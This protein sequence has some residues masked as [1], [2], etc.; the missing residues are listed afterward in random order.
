MRH[1]LQLFSFVPFALPGAQPASSPQARKWD[2]AIFTD[3]YFTPMYPEVLPRWR[4]TYD[5]RLRISELEAELRRE[6]HD[7]REKRR[8]AP[9]QP[10]LGRSH[11]CC[12]CRLRRASL[13]AIWFIRPSRVTHEHNV[14]AHS[15]SRRSAASGRPGSSARRSKPWRYLLH[16]PEGGIVRRRPAAQAGR[17]AE[18][19]W[20]GAALAHR[21]HWGAPKGGAGGF[22]SCASQLSLAPIIW[23]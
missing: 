9:F 14:T 2:V 1:C 10:K 4:I 13:L 21:R 7:K 18:K 23:R 20:A 3:H 15:G 22:R 8:C 17:T 5:L 11:A 19:L 16:L 12:L 6:A